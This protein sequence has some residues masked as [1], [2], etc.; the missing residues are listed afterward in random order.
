MPRFYFHT[1][2]G[3]CYPDQDGSDLPDLKAA[4]ATA[5]KVLA[6]HLQKKPHDLWRH[7]CLHLH[8]SD[9]RGMNLLTLTVTVLFSPALHSREHTARPDGVDAG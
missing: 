8:L 1:E 7:D 2:D 5:I 9:H 6:A 3:A 4:S